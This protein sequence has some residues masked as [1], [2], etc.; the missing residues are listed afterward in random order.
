VKP[1]AEAYEC[2]RFYVLPAG[3]TCRGRMRL[4]PRSKPQ[5]RMCDACSRVCLAEAIAIEVDAGEA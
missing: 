2:R 4:V 5:L 3:G 1:D